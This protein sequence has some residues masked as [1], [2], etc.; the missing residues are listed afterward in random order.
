[1]RKLLEKVKNNYAILSGITLRANASVKGK[2]ILWSSIGKHPRIDIQHAYIYL[3][4][5]HASH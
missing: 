1:M 3:E 5:L 2:F 4:D